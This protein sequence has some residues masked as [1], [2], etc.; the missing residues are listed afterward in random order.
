M[1]RVAWASSV[2]A[3]LD[4]GSSSQNPPVVRSLSEVT[5]GVSSGTVPKIYTSKLSRDTIQEHEYIAAKSNRKRLC[6][7]RSAREKEE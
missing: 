3:R 7:L 4:A 6:V 2:L 1:L 5:S